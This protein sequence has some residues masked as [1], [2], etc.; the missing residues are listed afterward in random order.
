M[1]FINFFYFCFSSFSVLSWRW[2][3]LPLVLWAPLSR[4]LGDTELGAREPGGVVWSPLPLLSSAHLSSAHPLSS[5]PFQLQPHMLTLSEWVT[6]SNQHY[7][8]Y[9]FLIILCS[10]NNPLIIITEICNEL[11]LKIS[12]TRTPT[13]YFKWINK[14]DDK[15]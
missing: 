7:I 2:H 13:N 15:C 5:K 1:L 6:Y 10:L 14:N 4:L 11:K 9:K 3:P 8:P 12:T